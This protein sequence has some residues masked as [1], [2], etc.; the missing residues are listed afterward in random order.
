M[1]REAGGPLPLGA[2]DVQQ[3]AA[4]AGQGRGHCAVGAPQSGP[5][6]WP[7][8]RLLGGR[9]EAC[10]GRDPPRRQRDWWGLAA[11]TSSTRLDHIP[12]VTGKAVREFRS[13][14]NVLWICAFKTRLRSDVG[15]TAWG[16]MAG[17]QAGGHL[18]HV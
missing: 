3:T 2:P 7:F 6:R 5:G 14:R 11:V 18:R 12:E 9:D 8:Q 10:T 13:R 16:A 15:L 4:S 1:K 17:V